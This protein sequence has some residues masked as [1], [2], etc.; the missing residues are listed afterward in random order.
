MREDSVSLSVLVSTGRGFRLAEREAERDM[1]E[2]TAGEERKY[3]TLEDVA[4]LLGVNYQLIYR[5]VRSGELAAIRLGRVYRIERADLE[6]YLEANKTGT[7][8]H[9]CATCGKT[10]QSATFLAQA[11]LDCGAAVCADCWTRLGVRKCREHEE[12]SDGAIQ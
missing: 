2:D 4:E 5:L 12:A 11:C 6:A 3:L 7:A 1:T 10:Y 9:V 8:R